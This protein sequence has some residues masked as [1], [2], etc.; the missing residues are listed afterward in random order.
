MKVSLFQ[1]GTNTNGISNDAFQ[2]I[3]T[4]EFWTAH[5]LCMNHMQFF[6]K[7]LLDL[8]G[9]DVFQILI[10]FIFFNEKCDIHLLISVCFG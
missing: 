6:I 10:H 2:W 9:Q 1:K 4:P 8:H 7:H 3:H 5:I